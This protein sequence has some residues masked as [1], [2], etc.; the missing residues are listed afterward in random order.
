LIF[1][2]PAFSRGFGISFG[3]PIAPLASL[4]LLAVVVARARR[5]AL[6]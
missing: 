5:E 6:G 3:V 1:I 2:A 4:A